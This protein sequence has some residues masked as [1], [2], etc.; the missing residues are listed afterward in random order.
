MVTSTTVDVED[1]PARAV[2]TKRLSF[3]ASGVD[4][5]DKVVQEVRAANRGVQHWDSDKPIELN[6]NVTIMKLILFLFMR[7][8]RP[9]PK[10]AK[11]SSAHT[12]L[13]PVGLIHTRPP[14]ALS[15]LV[16]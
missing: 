10:P 6:K 16:S 3:I 5:E 9:W 14:S 7:R 1:P 11:A 2:P 12:P 4:G 13:P 8:K 15:Q